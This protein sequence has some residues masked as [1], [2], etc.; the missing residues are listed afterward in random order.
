LIFVPEGKPV[1][2]IGIEDLIIVDT[3]DALLV[4]SASASQDLKKVVQRLEEESPE[5]L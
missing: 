4:C 1:V 3:G 2:T 5:L